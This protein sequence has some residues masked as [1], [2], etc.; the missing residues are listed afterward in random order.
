ML[1]SSPNKQKKN[2]EKHTTTKAAEGKWQAISVLFISW[3]TD[4][5]WLVCMLFCCFWCCFNKLEKIHPRKIWN[6][7]LPS[8]AAAA[9]LLLAYNWLTS[10]LEIAHESFL[11][12]FFSLPF[13]CLRLPFA[14]STRQA[15]W[16]SSFRFN[17]EDLSSRCECMKSNGNHL[18]VAYRIVIFICSI[19]RENDCQFDK[20]TPFS[21]FISFSPSEFFV[22]YLQK[23]CGEEVTHVD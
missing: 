4:S 23:W 3:I 8:A 10:I 20:I 9:A 22:H 2:E 11:R 7:F 15:G 12:H 14:F 17:V 5:G 16:L 19:N 6:R 18:K 13:S 1:Q 21:A